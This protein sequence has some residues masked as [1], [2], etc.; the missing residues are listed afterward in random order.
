[1]FPTYT[2]GDDALVY[3]FCVFH[4]Q[5]SLDYVL[6][7]LPDGAR[8]E[9]GVPGVDLTLDRS[10]LRDRRKAARSTTHSGSAS[11]KESIAECVSSIADALRQ[12]IVFHR[13]KILQPQPGNTRKQLVWRLP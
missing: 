9:C 2:Q 8:A 1:V 11:G 4:D 10:V 13:S 3:A 6:R 7:L 5:P 12:L